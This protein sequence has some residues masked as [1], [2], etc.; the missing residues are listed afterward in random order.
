MCYLLHV[1][2]KSS[3]RCLLHVRKDTRGTTMALQRT[4]Y[5]IRFYQPIISDYKVQQQLGM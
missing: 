1:P 4:E 3:L 5:Y 2:F